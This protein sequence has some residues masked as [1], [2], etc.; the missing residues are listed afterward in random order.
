MCLDRSHKG[1]QVQDLHRGFG[2]V[3]RRLQHRSQ[4]GTYAFIASHQQADGLLIMKSS[5]FFITV[6]VIFLKMQ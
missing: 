6:H 1:L 5:L 4:Q 2:A 3:A